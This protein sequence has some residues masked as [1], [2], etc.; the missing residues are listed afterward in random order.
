VHGG[1]R[2]LAREPQGERLDKTEN[3]NPQRSTH[4]PF[5]VLARPSA[6]AWKT[7]EEQEG[8]GQHSCGRW[9]VYEVDDRDEDMSMTSKESHGWR[10]S[11]H[12]HMRPSMPGGDHGVSEKRYRAGRLTTMTHPKVA[13][14]FKFCCPP[15]PRDLS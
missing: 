2:R 4:T 11:S 6:I 1:W 10:D 12:A 5:D 13:P 8:P 9:T 14:A 3:P 7:N 15:R